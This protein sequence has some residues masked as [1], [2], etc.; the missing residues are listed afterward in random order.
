LRKSHERRPRQPPSEQAPLTIHILGL[1]LRCKQAGVPITNYG[2]V[3]A[4]SLG[5]FERALEPFPA[6]LDVY[7]D[8]LAR[9]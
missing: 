8:A 1:I 5:T 6:A 9:S 3:V 7:R 4:Y 2:L